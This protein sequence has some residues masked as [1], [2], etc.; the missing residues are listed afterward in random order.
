M[1]AVCFHGISGNAPS[2]HWRAAWRLRRWSRA[3][4]RRR[5]TSV[6]R[7]RACGRLWNKMLATAVRILRGTSA[8][9]E[10]AVARENPRGHL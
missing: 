7:R 5:R 6:E 1:P 4:Q 9:E 3:C 10:I 2:S 8:E